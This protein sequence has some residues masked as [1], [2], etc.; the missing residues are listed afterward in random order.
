MKLHRFYLGN[1]P[2]TRDF[3]MDDEHLFH[4]WTK[5]LRFD[6]DREVEL[7]NSLG[8]DRLYK[9]LKVGDNAAHVELIT[10]MTPKL[11]KRELYLCFS[12]LKKDKNDWVLQKGTELGVSHF[13]PLVSDRTEK[14][15]FN[16]ERA[17]KIVIEAAEQSGRSDIPRLREPITPKSLIHELKD[18]VHLLIAEQSSADPQPSTLNPQSPL[19]VLVGPEGGWT[20]KEKQ[21]FTDEGVQHIAISE[22]TLRAETAA[23]TAAALLQ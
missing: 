16:T 5:V 9:I 6:V 18:K 1:T 4:Q 15:G 10:D 11:P 2:L 23:I 19:A 17:Q 7:F 20:D 3:W 12:L 8:E 21:M 13:V 22:F 14:T